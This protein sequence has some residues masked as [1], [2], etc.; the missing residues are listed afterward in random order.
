MWCDKLHLFIHSHK[1][2]HKKLRWSFKKKKKKKSRCAV[3]QLRFLFFY[4]TLCGC[5]DRF[6]APT[7]INGRCVGGGGL[8][9]TSPRPTDRRLSSLRTT[10]PPR[11]FLQP[12][13]HLRTSAPPRPPHQARLQLCFQFPAP[14]NH[15]P[16][17]TTTTASSPP[18]PFPN[19][20]S[21]LPGDAP[22]GV[23]G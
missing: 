16:P 2:Q 15:H 22:R 10:F 17:L 21:S 5:N 1:K 3:K 9:S 4:S 8:A 14:Y 7:F 6:T 23:R 11:S 18:T 12:P 19:L 13:E 20:T